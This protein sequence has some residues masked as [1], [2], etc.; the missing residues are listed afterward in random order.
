[1]K[2][3]QQITNKNQC[4]FVFLF[5]LFFIFI[6]FVSFTP[7]FFIFERKDGA[8]SSASKSC[9]YRG[10]R[11]AESSSSSASSTRS[12][13]G[14]E[15]RIYCLWLVSRCSAHSRFPLVSRL[16]MMNKK[17]IEDTLI[18]RLPYFLFLLYYFLVNLPMSQA[19]T[20]QTL[21]GITEIDLAML[22]ERISNLERTVIAL[23]KEV[24]DLKDAQKRHR[25]HIDD[26]EAKCGQERSWLL[27]DES[28][29]AEHY[30][31]RP[32]AG[33]CQHLNKK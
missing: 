21:T 6:L 30:P 25:V 29:Y 12:S 20:S 22:Y 33:S 24:A 8:E 31:F 19:L 7:Y 18:L 27:N 2:Q 3:W 28:L 13:I 23:H 10:A 9:E 15:S 4:D 14:S 17:Q 5:T 32:I 26:L 16:K 11:C 1:M